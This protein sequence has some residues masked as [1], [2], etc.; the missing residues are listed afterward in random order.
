LL[1]QKRI[2][3]GELI[4][5][6]TITATLTVLRE[7]FDFV[8]V[9][10]GHQLSEGSVAAW[11]QSQQLIYIID[12]SVTSVRPAQ[13]FLDL[14]GRLH[15]KDLD[16]QFVLNRFDSNHPFSIEKIETA[17]K[18]TL[19]ACIPRDNAAFM[20]AQLENADLA[21]TAPNSPGGAAV[22]A[23]ARNLCRMPETVNG[24]H[25]AAFFS[26][27]RTAVGF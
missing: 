20:Q 4:S 19:M 13:R 23:I 15:L 17:L 25:R 12:Q 26:R 10:C 22:D 9:D 27:L 8:L 5:V 3:E 6:S 24:R 21:V 2:E 1:R 7:L 11:E 16:P 14:F 18:R